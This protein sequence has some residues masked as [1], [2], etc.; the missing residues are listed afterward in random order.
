MSVRPLAGKVALVTGAARG[1][2]TGIARGLA[3]AG[4]HLCVLDIEREELGLAEAEIA[5]EGSAAGGELLCLVADVADFAQVQAAVDRAVGQW[6]RLDVMVNNAAI[7]PRV[8]FEET[9][10]DLW[11]RILA[12]N[13]TGVYHGVKAVWPQMVRQGGGHCI[14]IAS[15]S[16][17]YGSAGE[18]AYCASKHG[19]EGFSKAL[20]VEAE[21][22]N[23]AVN[24]I[25]PGKRIKPTSVTR[26]GAGALPLAEQRIWHNPLVLAPAFVWLALQPPARFTGMRFDA[27]PIVDAIA[28]EGYDFAFAPEKVTTYVEDFVQRQEQRRRWTQLP[29][30]AGVT[31]AQ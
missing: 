18:A 4:A 10:P 23:I 16:S 3:R 24:T 31:T 29:Q 2:G 13:L 26:A 1:F 7:L 25:G 28:A 17:V 14:A 9:T 22:Y 12:V 19:L 6:G 15:G 8:T 30:A 21:P 11:Q 5:A 27:G 20:A